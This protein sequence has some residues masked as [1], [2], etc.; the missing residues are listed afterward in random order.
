MI[1]YKKI[2]RSIFFAY[3]VSLLFVVALIALCELNMIP[4]EGL[5]IDGDGTV[6]YVIEAAMFFVVGLGLLATLKGF[7]WCL[8]HKVLV[9]EGK[10]RSSIYTCYSY[11]LR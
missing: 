8:H 9:E 1:D 3:V 2:S 7:H 10:R 4:M 6:M 5:L 11:I